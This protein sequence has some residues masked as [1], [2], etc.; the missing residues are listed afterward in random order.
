MTTTM[1]PS[2]FLPSARRLRF[3]SGLRLDSLLR[4]GRHRAFLRPAL[5]RRGSLFR[6]ERWAAKER[7][8]EVPFALEGKGGAPALLSCRLAAL[9]P[10]ACGVAS[11][12]LT[13][14]LLPLVPCGFTEAKPRWAV[15]FAGG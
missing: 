1:T 14:P 5:L 2:L 9:P 6:E 15:G 10:C 4:G 8:M 13:R 3:L 11:C 12:V 7:V